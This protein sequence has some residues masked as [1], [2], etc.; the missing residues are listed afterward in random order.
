MSNPIEK[1]TVIVVSTFDAIFDRIDSVRIWRLAGVGSLVCRIE[2][3]R[4]GMPRECLVGARQGE[5]A[6]ALLV[7][8]LD[9][10]ASKVCP[11]VAAHPLSLPMEWVP[12]RWKDEAAG[13]LPIA[14]APPRI[15]PDPW[16]GEEG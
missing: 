13:D 16:P 5:G 4:D 2:F 3:M 10:I 8:A 6:G 1:D 14:H 11:G 9:E 15:N 12:F 7:R